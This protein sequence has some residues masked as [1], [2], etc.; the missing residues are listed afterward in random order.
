MQYISYKENKK[1]TTNVLTEQ[2]R[3]E[4]NEKYIKTKLEEEKYFLDKMF[5]KIDKN[6][7]LDNQQREIILTEED[8]VMVIAGAGSG[9]TTTISAKVNYLIQRKKISEKD[10][11]VITYTNKAVNELKERINKDF[12]INIK[13]MTFHKFGY[14][15]IKHSIHPFPKIN[16]NKEEI[17]NQIIEKELLTK[18][19]RRKKKRLLKKTMEY[20][21][22]L[23]HVIKNKKQE[24]IKK[25]CLTII[26]LIKAR[27]YGADYLD[28]I[29][30]TT[31]KQKRIIH[32]TKKVLTKYEQYQKQNNLID[33]EDIINNA[34]KIIK[35]KKIN[36]RYRYI[37]IDEYQDISESR[38]N[39][40]MALSEN[41]QSK[42]ITVGD[43]WQCIYG[44]AASNI[45]LF[46]NIQKKIPY[47]EIM[48]LEKTYRNSQELIN[49]AGNFIK[50]NNKQIDKQ[51][52]SNKHN[53]NPV[54]HN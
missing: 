12:N 37:I 27:G 23:V 19:K 22:N 6:I 1:S 41:N 51:L 50:K 18:A 29:K 36:T 33:F 16:K 30:K 3:K 47:C 13:I 35:D 10:I 38:Y 44:F 21:K 25:L 14:E 40:I 49:I 9:K 20:I 5:E 28:K 39:L 32:F 2:Q 54:K 11:V 15:I 42:V 45:N 46:T 24:P 34:T 7:I 17:I 4:N 48:K 52:K 8:Y 53:Q 43:D 31:K 26:S